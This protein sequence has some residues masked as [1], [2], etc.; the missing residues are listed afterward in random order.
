MQKARRE[1]YSEGDPEDSGA[2]LRDFQNEPHDQPTDA[3][4]HETGKLYD[5]MQR[6]FW[7]GSKILLPFYFSDPPISGSCR[8]TGSLR[9]IYEDVWNEKER[10]S[11]I[12][13]ILEDVARTVQCDVSAGRMK[14]RENL[15]S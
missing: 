12:R 9:I 3:S 11:I 14:Q 13:E 10:Q 1:N 15:T 2:A 6:A 7:T 4:N 5:R 8:F